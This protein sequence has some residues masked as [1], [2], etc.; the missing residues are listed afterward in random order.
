MPGSVPGLCLA[1]PSKSAKRS[2]AYPRSPGNAFAFYVFVALT[3]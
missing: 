2:Q 3:A 1:K